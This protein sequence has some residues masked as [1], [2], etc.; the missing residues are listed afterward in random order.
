MLSTITG[1]QGTVSNAL[2][3]FRSSVEMTIKWIFGKEWKERKETNESKML[4]LMSQN[5]FSR[6]PFSLL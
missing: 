6:S 2:E 4:L 3:T 1:I 5:A